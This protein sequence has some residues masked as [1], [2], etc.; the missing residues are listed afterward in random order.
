M[1]GLELNKD[2]KTLLFLPTREVA[3]LE[4]GTPQR[5]GGWRTQTVDDGERANRI[6]Y[7]FEG[8]SPEPLPVLWSFSALNQLRG[9]FPAEVNGGT[10]AIL[11][12]ESSIRDVIAFPKTAQAVDL[13][14]DA[15][16]TVDPR[17]LKE[18]RLRVEP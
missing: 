13:M 5:K 3:I 1:L 11:C 2:G 6:H 7:T 17:Q 10:V 18:L 16:S 14:A 4:D 8:E 12:G 15:P 9:M